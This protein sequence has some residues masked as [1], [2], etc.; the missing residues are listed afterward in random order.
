MVCE[1][2]AW[3]PTFQGA[4]YGVRGGP[5][6]GVYT[7]WALAAQASQGISG[8]L[9]KKFRELAAAKAFAG[10]RSGHH[11]VSAAVTVTETEKKYE[12]GKGTP[13]GGQHNQW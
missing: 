11:R 6:S 2:E 13:K 1:A 9:C 8:A 5:R 12:K 7:S 3:H 4:F 10:G